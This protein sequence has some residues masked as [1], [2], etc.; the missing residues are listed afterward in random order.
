MT[1]DS[2]QTT[3]ARWGDPIF[4]LAWLTTGEREAAQQAAVR[5]LHAAITGSPADLELRLYR[6]L[7]HQPRRSR[8]FARS[9]LPRPLRRITPSDRLLLGLWLLRGLDGDR[10][11]AVFNTQPDVMTSRIAAM[12]QSPTESDQAEQPGDHLTLRSWLDYQLGFTPGLPQHVR[13]CAACR[14][15]QARWH[16]AVAVRREE[17]REVVRGQ[18]LPTTA[19]AELEDA[20]AAGN[21]ADGAWWQQRRVWL[22]ALLGVIAILLLVVIAP[23]GSNSQTTAAPLTAQALVQATL[24]EW[25][26]PPDENTLHR[27]VWAR[28]PYLHGGEP[29]I[30]DVWIPAS[31]S[32]HRVEVRRD[33][34]LVEWQVALANGQLGYGAQPA[35]TSCRWN[36][37]WSGNFPLFERAA[38]RFNTTADQ[39]AAVLA[40]RLQQGA[41]GV[42]YVALQDALNAD[43]LRSFGTRVENERALTVLGFTERRM[44]TPRQIV[45]RID[46]Q[47]R[48]LISVQEIVQAANQAQTRDL[49]RLELSELVSTLPT[50]QPAW[51]RPQ[52]QP[53]IDPACPALKSD[54]VVGV[55]ALTNTA[56]RWYV[57]N[58]LPPG[59]SGAAFVRSRDAITQNQPPINGGGNILY[60]GPGRFLSLSVSDWRSGGETGDSVN[61]GAW[62]VLFRSQTGRLNGLIQAQTGAET[63]PQASIEFW[64]G[65]LSRDELLAIVQTLV[66][67]NASTWADVD[68]HFLDP[69]PLPA[70]VRRVMAQ[71]IAALATPRDGTLRS[72]VETTVRTERVADDPPDP[73]HLSPTLRLPA[74]LVQT[75][76]VRY[77]NDRATQFRAERALPDGAIY[78]IWQDTGQQFGW[79]NTPAGTLYTGQS[80]YLPTDLRP[81]PPQLD[82]LATLLARAEPITIS[83]TDGRW[84]LIQTVPGDSMSLDGAV[85]LP[86]VPQ[87]PFT[88]DLPP[89]DYVQRLWLDSRTAL[90]QR[91]EIIHRDR[92]GREVRLRT[93]QA[94]EH[95][96]LPLPPDALGVLPTPAAD[97]LEWRVDNSGE[98]DLVT[99]FRPIPR[100]LVWRAADGITVSDAQ[101]SLPATPGADLNLPPS[102]W[103][104][105]EVGKYGRT[106]LYELDTGGSVRVTHG[107]ADLMRNILRYQVH[108]NHRIGRLAWQ[109]SEPA[110]V[111]IDG[112]LRSGWLLQNGDEG[113]L[114]IEIDDTILHIAAPLGLLNGPFL[115]RLPELEWVNRPTA[116]Q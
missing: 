103:Q 107:P 24:D 48:Q 57:A 33:D 22:P 7:A 86:G 28:D 27:Q 106:T 19:V 42:G 43:D 32:A 75:Q 84:L 95:G 2:W 85:G 26:V 59:M 112:E 54:Q 83:Q 53:L 89:G 51:G 108:N 71:S 15:R 72:V 37:G 14:E 30:T 3:I 41:Y 21:T 58:A 4:H 9:I 35:D 105:I 63:Q 36:T 69:Q 66:P 82:L 73:Y 39:S 50:N 52:E 8:P 29:V 40:A 100:T 90:P 34:A 111:T 78:D 93:V 76:T 45:L 1:I 94:I 92:Q 55:R 61:A 102:S 18:R 116:A 99:E 62:R 16:E 87:S 77:E 11:R 46:P 110:R 80:S 49:W 91:L 97:M 44:L 74:T 31:G 60:V 17:L 88:S 113:A 109:R 70:P 25:A 13:T 104:Q 67:L 115:D 81:Q 68:D 6:A 56:G 114:V 5:A 38:L 64:A 20:L 12:L 23:G 98:P 47:Q 10:L 101:A 65:G 96:E 79:L